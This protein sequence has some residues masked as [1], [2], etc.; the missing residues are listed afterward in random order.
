MKPS[1]FLLAGAAALASASCSAKKANDVA[2]GD[3]TTVLTPVKPPANGDWSTVVSET[4]AGGYLMGNPNAK[5]HLVEYGSLTCPHCREF[6]ETGVDPLVNKYVKS[7]K[8][9]YEF[10]N[11]VR[12]PFDIAAALIARCNGSQSFFALTRALYKAQPDW[13]GKIQAV[14]QGEVEALQNMPPE[15]EF[16]TIAT[17]G[18]LQ[19]FAAMRGVPEA[20]S[21]QCLTNKA[22]V[23]QLVQINSDANDQYN[24]PGTP[25]F[26]LN[27]KVVEMKPT[28]QTVWEQLDEQLQTALGG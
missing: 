3:S 20:K 4:S 8:V 26:L 12:D 5:A 16:L 17:M 11:Y 6:D 2:A 28:R 21:T 15:K 19:K 22:K 13:V 24:I 10:R 27:G 18:D 25:T 7:G 1:L 9:S 14:P 23:D